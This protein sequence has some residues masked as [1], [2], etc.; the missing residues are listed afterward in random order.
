MGRRAP[1]ITQR[2]LAKINLVLRIRGR[3][4][5]GYHEVD[6]LL[7][8]IGLADDVS[9]VIRPGLTVRCSDV[10]LPVDDRN[11]AYRAARLLAEACRGHR[12]PGALIR[13]RKR[14]PVAAGLAG[15]SADAA[16][17]LTLLNE[18]WA[19]GLPWDELVQI[20]RRIGADVPFCLLG[21]AARAT[22]IGERLQ[23]LE[24]RPGV[25][26]VLIAWADGLETAEV[27]RVY[28]RLAPGS[29]ARVEPALQALAAGDLRALG[30]ALANDLQ[31]VVEVLRPETRVARGDLLTCGALGAAVT[32]SGPTVFGIFSNAERARRAARELAARWPTVIATEF[33]A[34]GLG[35]MRTNTWARR[36]GP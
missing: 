17:V 11:L 22:G 31:P 5:D 2:A 29:T 9:V 8:T 27:Y 12:P 20:A 26:V 4:P 19:C 7:H 24:P 23:P 36:D 35:S 25:P 16:A 1:V 6:S 14:I 30:A 18:A 3:R 32:G 34:R 10:D 15:G 28:D 13:L 21:G 33:T